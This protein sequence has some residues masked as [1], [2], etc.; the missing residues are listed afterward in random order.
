MWSLDK[1]SEQFKFEN[2]RPIFL[3]KTAKNNDGHKRPPSRRKWRKVK[4]KITKQIDFVSSNSNL[5]KRRDC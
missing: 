4:K 2:L 3:G 5:A 1:S